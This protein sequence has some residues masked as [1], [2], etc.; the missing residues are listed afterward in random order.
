MDFGG[1]FIRGLIAV[2]PA[3]TGFLPA[4]DG[5]LPAFAGIFAWD[6]GYFCLRLKVCFTATVGV[7]AWG[8]RYFACVCGYFCLGLQLLLPAIEGMFACDCGCFCLGL[9]VFFAFDCGCFR[10]QIACIFAFRSRQF[11]M[12]VAGEFARVPHLKTSV[13]YP[14]CSGKFTCGCRQ[15]ACILREVL[16][17]KTQVNL[18]LFTGKLHVTNVNCPWGISECG[19]YVNS[20][21]FVGNFAR[22]S[23]TV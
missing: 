3:M 7:F 22:A 21:A 6:C 18:P 8:C 23:F 13:K 10:L 14:L 1:K 9:Q 17:P 19:S 4:T 15:F 20:P 5:I 12:A 16:A 11:C 2:L